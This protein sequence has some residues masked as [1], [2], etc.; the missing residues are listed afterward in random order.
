M[1]IPKSTWLP[2]ALAVYLVVMAYIGLDGLRSGQ[3]STAMY[4]SVLVVCIA[5]LVGL[6]FNLKKREKL[7]REREE[8]IRNSNENSK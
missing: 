2:A 6:H 5:V 3:T 4:V 7:K 8:D 1:K